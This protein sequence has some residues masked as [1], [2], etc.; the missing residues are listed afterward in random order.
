MWSEMRTKNTVQTWFVFSFWTV[1]LK[2][3]ICAVLF[4]CLSQTSV[5][6]DYSQAVGTPTFTSAEPV[7]LGLVD[8][9]NG[10]LHMEIPMASFPQRGSKPLTY[11]LVYDSRLWYLNGG[12]AFL[13]NGTASPWGGWRFITSGDIGAHDQSTSTTF[14]GSNP[15]LADQK[16]NNFWWR[17]P[18]GTTH[19]FGLTLQFSNNCGGTV[20]LCSA[21]SAAMQAGIT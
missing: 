12:T 19:Y 9:A 2:M 16:Q 4:A 18:D 13:P 20:Q 1:P 11:K 15:V 8:A 17:A 21:S 3:T 5:A 7:E 6:Q 14:C 10:N